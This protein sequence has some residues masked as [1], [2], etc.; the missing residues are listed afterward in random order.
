MDDQ[1]LGALFVLI[2]ATGFATLAVLG[3]LAF[4]AGLTIPTMLTLRLFI[5]SVIFLLLFGLSHAMGRKQRRRRCELDPES[6]SLSL[7][8]R[9]LMLAVGLGGVGYAAMSGL[10]FWGLEFMP[11]GMVAIVLYTYPVLVV[12]L[13]AIVLKERVTRYTIMALALSL[14]GLVLITGA[15]PTQVDPRGVAIVLS[16]AIIYATYITVSRSMLST[17]DARVLTA[18]V[19]PSAAASFLIYGKITDQ[20][21][22]PVTTYEWMIVIALAV[23]ATA[24]PVFT[25]FAGLSRIGA[26]RASIL[27]TFEPVITILLGA[28]LLGEVITSINILGGI[29]VLSGAILVHKA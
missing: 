3:K 28:I 17:I 26:N 27:S 7:K 10:F 22:L 8:G 6:L 11:V 16:A 9:E 25:F 23:A 12:V 24:V 21:T 19:L 4:I 2:S 20:L 1:K 18:Y 29:M 14:G 5:G 15:D 13:S